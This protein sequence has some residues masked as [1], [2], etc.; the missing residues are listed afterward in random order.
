M[1]FATGTASGHL[2]LWNKLLTFLTSHPDLV[3]DRQQW[4]IVWR[5]T[6]RPGSTEPDLL[7]RGPGLSE[8]DAIFVSMRHDAFPTEDRHYFSFRGAT[9]PMSTAVSFS[10][11]VHT[12]GTVRMFTNNG[13]MEYWFVANGRRFMIV[14]K[15]STVFEAAYCGFILPYATPIAYPYPLLVGG[16]AGPA[17]QSGSVTNWRSE[18]AYHT[19]FLYANGNSPSSSTQVDASSW[20]LDPSGQWQKMENNASLGLVVSPYNVGGTDMFGSSTDNSSYNPALLR[21]R[22]DPAFGG[23][24][25]LQPATIVQRDPADQTFGI[26]DGAFFVSGVGNAAENIIEY[27]GVDHLVVQNTFRSGF[28]DYWAMALE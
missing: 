2:D 20:L 8:Q 4:Q 21:Q 25:V 7:L 22:L 17:G 3:A 23:G 1:A 9:G 26:Y 10:G 14:V 28:G 19:N 12:S 24:Y 6:D 11:H 27:D 16:S 13:P 15:I 5:A 18:S